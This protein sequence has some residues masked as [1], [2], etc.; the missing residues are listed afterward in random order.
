MARPLMQR[1]GQAVWADDDLERGVVVFE[2]SVGI[3]RMHTDTW[4]LIQRDDEVGGTYAV[5]RSRAMRGEQTVQ[6][7]VVDAG[8]F[9]L[10]PR[11]PAEPPAGFDELREMVVPLVQQMVRLSLSGREITPTQ[12]EGFTER[13]LRARDGLRQLQNEV[14][15][16]EGQLEAAAAQ[17]REF[18]E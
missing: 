11:P 13:Y 15:E 8:R 6:G 2:P 1:K 16:I 9:G 14:A 7:V 12:L 5:L 4:R 3:A 18:N 17:L 10:P